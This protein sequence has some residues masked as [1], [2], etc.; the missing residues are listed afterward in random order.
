MNAYQSLMAKQPNDK[1][2]RDELACALFEG[3]PH[4]ANLAEK[5][6]RQHGQADALT[7]FD[8]M[9]EEVKNFYKLIA[10]DLIDHASHWLPNKGSSCVLGGEEVARLKSLPRARTPLPF[11]WEHPK[12]EPVCSCEYPKIFHSYPYE[13]QS[14]MKLLPLNETT[15]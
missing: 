14:C 10:D 3:S 2:T 4:V 5:L 7:Y 6:A 9:G 8:M 12:G 11:M 13:C 1:L 15:S